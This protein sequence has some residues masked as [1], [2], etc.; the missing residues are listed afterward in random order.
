MK[1]EDEI[2]QDTFRNPIQKAVVNML[3]TGSWFNSLHQAELKPFKISPQQYNILR[4]LRGSYPNPVNVKTLMDRMLDKM[5]NASR[6]VEKLVQRNLVKRTICSK[7][8]RAVDVVI[9]GEGLRFLEK[10][11]NN[12]KLM[13]R[14]NMALTDEEA[15]T[16]SNLLD[17]LREI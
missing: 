1:I 10:I 6:L 16:L 12:R 5:S 11:E 3:F 9:T 2:K 7:D 13:H 4:I 17:K 15:L 8:R 14:L